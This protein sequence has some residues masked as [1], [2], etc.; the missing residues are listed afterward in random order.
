MHK[1]EG[2]G[3]GARGGELIAD[4]VF[5]GL[6]VVV[7]ALLEGFHRRGRRRWRVAGETRRDRKE[8]RGQRGGRG[9][10]GRLLCGECQEPSRLDAD[11]MANQRRFGEVRPQDIGAAGVATV[12]RREGEKGVDLH[13]WTGCHPCNITIVAHPASWAFTSSD[14]DTSL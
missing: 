5:D 4:K 9:Q 13:A 2:G 7:G 11:T 8:R 10:S 6:H 3:S 1:F 14:L 12:D